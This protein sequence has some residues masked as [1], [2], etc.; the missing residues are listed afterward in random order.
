MAPAAIAKQAGV[1]ETS[2]TASSS[3]AAVRDSER[4]TSHSAASTS[5]ERAQD[6]SLEAQKRLLKDA[7][8]IA[9]KGN[10]GE[11]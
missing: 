5:G 8:G 10:V 11:G 7:M 4:L 2:G 9:E 6:D 3:S 1:A